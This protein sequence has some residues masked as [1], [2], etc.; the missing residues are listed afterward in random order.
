MGVLLWKTSSEC[1]DNS[2][3]FIVMMETFCALYAE[4]LSAPP[5]KIVRLHELRA[6]P[7]GASYEEITSRRAVAMFPYD[8]TVLSFYELYHANVPIFLPAPNLAVRYAFRGSD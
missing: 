7:S 8:V 6:Q 4:H 2:E 1:V 5:I 3:D